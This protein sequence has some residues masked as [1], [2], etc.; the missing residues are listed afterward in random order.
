MVIVVFI[1]ELSIGGAEK[2]SLLLTRELQ[3]HYRTLLVVWEPGHPAPSYQKF[4]DH[5]GLNVVY[6]SGASPIRFYKFWQLLVREKVTHIFNFLL[7]NNLV[8]GLA[9][10]LAAVP[11]IF[12]GIRNCELVRSKFLWQ[13]FLHNHISHHSIFNN[14]AGARHLKDRGFRPDKIMMIHNGIDV[15]ESIPEKSSDG[16]VIILTAARFLPQKDHFTALK[17]IKILKMKGYRFVYVIAG[18]GPGEP[19]IRRWVKELDVEDRVRIEISPSDLPG[20]FARSHIYLT[21]SVKEGLSNSVMEAMSAGLPVVATD[22][23]DNRYL[24]KDG[25]TG[26]LIPR[27]DHQQIADFLERLLRDNDLRKEMGENG[28]ERLKSGFSA[29]QF[30]NNYLKLLNDV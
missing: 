8:G 16:P 9:G 30:L 6:L 5:Y 15:N 25:V 11:H 13:K 14:Y 12:G 18:Y 21:T 23:G 28:Y 22:V 3:G 10:R 4:I 24:V 27:G 20:L 1:K 29:P 26:T 19:D 17:A 7:V 2:Q